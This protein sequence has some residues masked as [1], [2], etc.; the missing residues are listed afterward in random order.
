MPVEGRNKM[1][2]AIGA[3]VAVGIVS[4]VLLMKRRSE[5]AGTGPQQEVARP[6][7]D[8]GE[9]ESD[10]EEGFV[11]EVKAPEVVAKR[12]VLVCLVS[13]L[14][15]TVELERAGGR[16]EAIATRKRTLD[17]LVAFGMTPNDL[18]SAEQR[19]AFGLHTGKVEGALVIEAMWRLEDAAVL[20]WALGLRESI[21]TVGEAAKPDGL[22]ALLP[23]N[24]TEFQ[25]FCRSAKVR[26]LGELMKARN[27]W[28]VRFF[29]VENQG[30]S[31]E[32]SRILER[33]R[34]LRWLTEG[35]HKELCL[36][37]VH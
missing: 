27:E 2:W 24:A 36:T 12:F 35:E 32:R 28:A 33:I 18:E 11:L 6:N 8:A 7:E 10:E 5:A 19:L 22:K 26:P 15:D 14:A 30:P 9:P 3:V 29:P 20:A 31:E 21:L 25:S 1:L 23:K 4:G 13:D 37:P 17:R 16:T 34:A